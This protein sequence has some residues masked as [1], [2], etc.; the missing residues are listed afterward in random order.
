MAQ[1]NPAF[2]VLRVNANAL[3]GSFYWAPGHPENAGTATT[4]SGDFSAY[5]LSPIRTPLL[6]VPNTADYCLT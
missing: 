3:W 1:N 6:L 2:P 5:G 4:G